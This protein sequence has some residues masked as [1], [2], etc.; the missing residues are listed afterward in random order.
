MGMTLSDLVQG[1]FISGG[2]L[3]EVLRCVVC[4]CAVHRVL[5]CVRLPQSLFYTGL[6]RHPKSKVRRKFIDKTEREH[7]R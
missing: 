1:G 7:K 2:S 3:V 6:V 5:C 4:S